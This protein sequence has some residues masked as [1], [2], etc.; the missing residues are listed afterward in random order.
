MFQLWLAIAL[1]ESYQGHLKR[2]KKCPL[3]RVEWA[4]LYEMS[5]AMFLGMMLA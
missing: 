1:E 4:G 3:S 2:A 5:P